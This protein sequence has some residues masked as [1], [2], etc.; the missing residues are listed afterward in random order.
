MTLSQGLP[1]AS[2][3]LGR[4]S[5]WPLPAWNCPVSLSG[6]SWEVWAWQWMADRHTCG[7]PPPGSWQPFHSSMTGA[8]G[9]PESSHHSLHP[10]PPGLRVRLWLWVLGP[11]CYIA[12]Q[13]RMSWGQCG[14]PRS[15]GN[16][17]APV[18][19]LGMCF[20]LSWGRRRLY[21][22]GAPSLTRSHL[23]LS[24]CRAL[25]YIVYF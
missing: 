9:P 15:T 19:H 21:L 10:P 4:M 1:N 7:R 2:Q 17:G 24:V 12:S 25:L 5:P 13:D 18:P 11:G 23:S 20:L 6:S 22:L 16:R 8:L 3:A 14:S